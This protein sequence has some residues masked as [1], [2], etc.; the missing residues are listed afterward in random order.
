MNLLADGSVR[1]VGFGIDDNTCWFSND[2]VVTELSK[3]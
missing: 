2:G 1:N 3:F